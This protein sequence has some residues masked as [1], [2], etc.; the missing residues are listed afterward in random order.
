MP[1]SHSGSGHADDIGCAEGV[2]AVHEGDADVDFGGLAVWFPCSDALAEGLEAAHL[3]FGAAAGVVSAPPLP[4]CPTI[5]TRGSQVFVA[6]LGSRAVLFPSPTVPSDRDYCRAAA[7]DDGAL[8]APRVVG[9]VRGDG[10][11]LFVLGDLIHQV[12][13]DGTVAF[14]AG[15]EL[16][17]ADVGGGGVHG[18][19][20]LAPLASPLNAMIAGLPLAIAEELDTGAVHQQVQ[21]PAS[22]AIRDLHLQSLLPSAQRGVV[23]NRPIQPCEPQQTGDH[24]GGLPERELKQHLY[25]Q[26]ELDS[27][28]RKD[29]RAPLTALMRR[30]PG[31]LL[32]QPDQ[33]RPALPER[34]VVG[35][36]VRRAVA[37]GLGLAHAARLTAWIP[38]VNP[39]W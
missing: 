31:H 30:V 39:S 4:E 20:D 2:E 7:C 22:T 37:G 6:R 11:D 8:T 27:R 13:Q 5:V 9:A 29:R 12:R 21:W 28:I 10:G 23:R 16:D 34:I 17:G 26:A 38:D 18:K 25:R 19:M 15:G 14:P 35:G 36:P 33:Q 24:P 1:L 32:V 3:G